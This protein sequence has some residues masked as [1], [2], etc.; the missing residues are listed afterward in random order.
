MLQQELLKH[1]ETIWDQPD[2]GI[3]R[4]VAVLNNLLILK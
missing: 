2:E 4:C 3:G 1:L